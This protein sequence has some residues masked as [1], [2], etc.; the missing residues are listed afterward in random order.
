MCA[1]LTIL[2]SLGVTDGMSIVYKV[3]SDMK[4]ELMEQWSVEKGWRHCH[5]LHVQLM[6]MYGR[7]ADD[8]AAGT[9]MC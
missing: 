4:K 7:N 5:N 8:S 3:G 6:S 2:L 9:G 1:G